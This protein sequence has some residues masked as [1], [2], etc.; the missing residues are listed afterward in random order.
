MPKFQ[1]KRMIEMSVDKRF[2]RYLLHLD[3]AARVSNQFYEFI[4]PQ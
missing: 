2:E 1:D 4:V 3:M